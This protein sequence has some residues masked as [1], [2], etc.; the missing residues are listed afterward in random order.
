[1]LPVVYPQSFGYQTLPGIFQ[2]LHRF[3]QTASEDIDLQQYKQDLVGFFTSLPVQQINEAVADLISK[4]AE[5]QSLPVEEV[6]FTIQL[7]APESRLRV[8]Q[9]SYKRQ[10]ARTGIIHF[11]DLADICKLSLS[12][13]MFSQ[14]K[15][16]LKQ[17]RGSAVG[18]QISPSLANVAVSYLEQVWYETH[19][20][21]LAR[22]A[23]DV[24]I[25]WYDDNRLVL[26]CESVASTPHFQEFLSA[27]FYRRPVELEDVTDGE[28]L[29]TTLCATKRTL[30]FRQP[31]EP[32]QFRPINPAGTLPRKM[33]AALARIC[34][35]SRNCFPP[36]QAAEDVQTLIRTYTQYGYDHEELS[37]QARRFLHSQL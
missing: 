12:T 33:S 3:L 9:G 7:H 20:D 21:K 8:F 6:K 35:A 16:I 28:F 32:F 1:M 19:S 30:T 37:H 11:S 15:R 10:A 2:S 31:T 25:T 23:K 14:T 27:F 4:F 34:L 5:K 24:F 36:S 17:Q 22:V 13:S 18:N 29:G 26:C